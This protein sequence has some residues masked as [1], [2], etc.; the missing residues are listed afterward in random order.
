MR[1]KEKGTLTS[2]GLFNSDLH[3]RGRQR[4]GGEKQPRGERTSKVKT[5]EGRER[6]N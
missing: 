2:K 5:A 4:G 3:E 1:E 6:E